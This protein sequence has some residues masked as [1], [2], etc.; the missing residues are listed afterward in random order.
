MLMMVPSF[1]VPEKSP[2]TDIPEPLAVA[3]GLAA[4]D[5]Q[6]ASLEVAGADPTGADGSTGPGSRLTI[7]LGVGV[8]AVLA[9]GAF[10]GRDLWRRRNRIQG[11]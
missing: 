8:G 4:G 3:L 9:T 5:A 11:F 7:A 1:V 10:L 6:P 2:A